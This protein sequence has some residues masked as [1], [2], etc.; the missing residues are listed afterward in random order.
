MK[1]NIINLTLVLLMT[2]VCA[3]AAEP[4][5]T[6]DSVLGQSGKVAGE[7]HRYGWPRSDLR[8]VMR[9]VHVEPALALG[10][11]AAFSADMVMGDLVLRPGEV[12]SVVRG[13]QSGGFEIAAIHNHLLGESP[14]VVYVHYAGHGDP[15]AL[16]HAVRRARHHGD[17][18]EAE[19]TPAA[20]ERG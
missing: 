2:T 17:S 20:V 18:P 15:A 11:W 10:S 9:G 12:E 6:V 3:F 1:A 14:A 13:L 4:W 7:I 19:I 16:A 8:V 5:Q